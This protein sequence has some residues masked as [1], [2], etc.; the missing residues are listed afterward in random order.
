M[1]ETLPA[2]YEPAHL[3]RRSA[4]PIEEV[5]LIPW[6][7]EAIVVTL[8]CDEFTSLCPVT[9]QP[10]FGMIEISYMP[11][12]SLIESKSLKL[13]LL[14]FRNRGSFSE[15]LVD[16]IAAE[17]WRQAAPKWIRVA[18]SFNSRGGI[19]IEVEATRG[20]RE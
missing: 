1:D 17:L 3:G 11:N 15:T 10:D 4:D 6:K 20:E 18:G 13:Y 9:G 19:G 16:L 5:D 14:K 2:D 12:E 8:V 7:G